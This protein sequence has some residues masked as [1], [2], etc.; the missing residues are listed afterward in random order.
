MYSIHSPVTVVDAGKKEEHTRRTGAGWVDPFPSTSCC[1]FFYL[2]SFLDPLAGRTIRRLRAFRTPRL[3][4]IIA[5]APGVLTS[6][7]SKL[8]NTIVFERV[9][10]LSRTEDTFYNCK[11][12]PLIIKIFCRQK[13][14][15]R[16]SKADGGLNQ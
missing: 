9:L 1:S 7:G 14:V 4:N 15:T 11:K 12:S 10:I 2:S 8:L 3:M 5:C 6:E 13:R 16:Y